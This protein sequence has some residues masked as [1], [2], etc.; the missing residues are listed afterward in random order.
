MMTMVNNMEVTV[1]TMGFGESILLSDKTALL[2]D[3]GS[4]SISNSTYFSVIEDDLKE[5]EKVDALITHFHED[6]IN[7][8]FEVS[9]KI[10]FNRV[11]IP[12]IFC[13]KQHP[14]AVDISLLTFILSKRKFPD[15]FLNNRPSAGFSIM[16][17]LYQMMGSFTNLILLRREKNAFQAIDRQ[18]DVLWPVPEEFR[19][20]SVYDKIANSIVFDESI[21]YDTSDL[22]SNAYITISNNDRNINTSDVETNIQVLINSIQDNT[23]SNV[24][25]SKLLSSLKNST[26]QTS[27]VCQVK[28]DMKN[29]LLTGDITKSFLRKIARDKV[30]PSIP[31]FDEYY[32]IKAPHH[33]TKSHYFDFGKYTDYAY[34]IISNGDTQ[35][36]KVT[37]GKIYDKYSVPSRTYRMVCSNTVPDQCERLVNKSASCPHKTDFCNCLNTTNLR[38]PI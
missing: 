8:F 13:V 23:G 33:G 11:F 4:E 7:G 17:L 35:A 24:V 6:H 22:I 38:I 27:I 30:A 3:C 25:F 34:L 1:Y 15:R 36:P 29:L 21:I 12:D 26:N 28:D 32:A 14:N 20:H 5:Y 37:R 19:F 2:I 9:K 18:F 31:L 10:K 16:D